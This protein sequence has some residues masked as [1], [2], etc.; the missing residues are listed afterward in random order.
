[1]RDL[2]KIISKMQEF[3]YP[4]LKCPMC[5]EYSEGVCIECKDKL[6]RFEEITLEHCDTGISL[7][8]YNQAAKDLLSSY[9]KKKEFAA[10]E[11]LASLMIERLKFEKDT[12]DMITCAP[13]SKASLKALGFDHGAHLVNL[14]SKELGVPWALLFTPSPI[15][16]KG[17]DKEER[18]ANALAI[19]LKKEA[20]KICQ[21][22]RIL[23]IDDVYTTG[24]TVNRCI[25]LLRQQKVAVKFM[26]FARL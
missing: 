10:G 11:A 7:Y 15:V 26:T 8:T 18:L 14:I 13:S 2:S 6:I 19:S 22:K 23:I 17:L 21:G 20:I 1:M 4:V 9:K 5:K 24:S 16:Q 3:F 25:S 12:V